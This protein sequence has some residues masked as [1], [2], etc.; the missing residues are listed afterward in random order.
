VLI[1]LQFQILPITSQL[2]YVDSVEI[3][4]ITDHI[5]AIVLKFVAFFNIAKH[6]LARVC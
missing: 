2:A 3:T 5:L 6:I 4:N 1:V